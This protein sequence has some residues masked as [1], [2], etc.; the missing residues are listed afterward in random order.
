MLLNILQNTKFNMYLIKIYIKNY[1][2][3]QIINIY[4]NKAEIETESYNED[5]AKSD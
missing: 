4:I 5:E 1:T 3:S 2:G